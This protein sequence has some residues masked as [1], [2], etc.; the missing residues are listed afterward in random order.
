MFCVYKGLEVLSE[1]VACVVLGGYSPNPHF[2]IHV[3]LTDCVMAYVNG[4][5]VVVHIGLGSD[6]FS[7]LIVGEQEVIRLTISIEH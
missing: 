4:A 1:D 3:I 6:V 2:T 5:R 7:G